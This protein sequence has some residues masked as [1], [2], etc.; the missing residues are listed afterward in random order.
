MIQGVPVLAAI[1]RPREVAI[2]ELLHGRC[3]GL[4]I[5]KDTVVACIRLSDGASVSEEIRSFT[6]M[7][8]DILKLG[9]WLR[10][11]EVRPVAMEATGVYWK[12]IW[13]LLEE[14]FELMLVNA[15]HMRAVPGRKTDVKDSQW[16]A[17]LL[18]HG[19]LRPSFVPDRAARQLRELARWRVSLVQERNR[20]TNRIQKL[21]EDANI[22]LS[23]VA[24]DVLG[25][26]GRAMLDALAD[27]QNDPVVLA[28]LALRQLRGKIPKLREALRGG[29][30]EHHR[31][32]LREMLDQV[33]E[34]DRRIE[35]VEARIEEQT[36]DFRE[37]VA[38]LETIPGVGHVTAQSLVAE[39]GVDMNRFP[40]AG[41][42]ASWA[43]M[44]PGNHESAGKRHSGKTRPGN[45]WLRR[46]LI[47]AAW[48]AAR[49]KGTY[50]RAHYHRIAARRGRKRAIVA[51]G[52]TLLVIYWHMMSRGMNYAEMG[53]DY[54]NR[55][56]TERKTRRLVKQLQSLGH[57]VQLNA[58]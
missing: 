32:M 50:L 5:H 23:S 36:R 57:N 7:T 30:R 34:V 18:A 33:D 11:R 9:D 15:Q 45:K 26:S 19:L 14:E 17:Q 6:T 53:E 29:M 48:A 35:R 13:N 21:L 56:D 52:H 46:L 40:T 41:H 47:Q 49:A 51:V 28:E 24:S 54:L 58:A 2:M 55:L 44:C 1:S 20:V 10:E 38:R 25:K 12:P 42:L 39:I 43:G 22:K 31:F 3:C 8:R 4:D 37:A 27:G 16:I